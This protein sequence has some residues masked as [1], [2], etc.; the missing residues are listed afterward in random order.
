MVKSLVY[1][2]FLLP[3]IISC[4]FP[5]FEN[6]QTELAAEEARSIAKEVYIYGFLLMEGY[7]IQYASFIAREYKDFKAPWNQI[8]SIPRVF[9]PKDKAV[10]PLNSVTPYSWLG[11]DLRAEPI[12]LSL[13]AIEKG[14]YYSVQLIDAYTR[15]FNYLGTAR[16]GNQGGKFLIAGPSWKG[17]TPKGIEKVIQRE[18]FLAMALY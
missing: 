3:T 7:R 8:S 11:L 14:R 9:T 1:S 17:E 18:T 4:N 15:N 12:V 10:Q 16:A 6:N 13:P 5:N 2:V